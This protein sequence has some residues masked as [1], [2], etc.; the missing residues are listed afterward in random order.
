MADEQALSVDRDLHLD[1]VI[2]CTPCWV[3]HRARWGEAE[4]IAFELIPALLSV[5]RTPLEGPVTEAPRTPDPERQAAIDA[6][7]E[8]LLPV[9]DA[10][11]GADAEAPPLARL[12]HVE[13]SEA[14]GRHWAVMDGTDAALFQPMTGPWAM[15]E[16]RPVA[17]RLTEALAILHDAER[18]HL[19][20]SPNLLAWRDGKPVL[21]APAAEL[22]S[23]AEAPED[24]A[25]V[26]RTDLSPPELLDLSARSRVGPWTDI[27]LASATLFQLVTDKAPPALA[28][29][30]A[31][32]EAFH[33]LIVEE[34]APLGAQPGLLTAISR[35][36][37][38]RIA[39][40][41]QTIAQWAALIAEDATDP[42]P[43]PLL[44]E[45]EQ[46]EE[47]VLVN[48]AVPTA[49]PP[50][51]CG[52][53]IAWAV[54]FLIGLALPIGALAMTMPSWRLFLTATLAEAG[55]VALLIGFV[56][57][58]PA[59]TL[60]VGLATGYALVAAVMLVVGFGQYRAAPSDHW[61][62]VAFTLPML[63]IV[64]LALRRG[65]AGWLAPVAVGLAALLYAALPSGSLPNERAAP[66]PSPVVPVTPTPAPEPAPTPPPPAPEPAPV[67]P[68]VVNFANG[69]PISFA[70]LIDSFA[71][72]GDPDCDEPVRITARRN[73]DDRLVGL[74]I[75]RPNGD[76]WITSWEGTVL[77]TA[78]PASPPPPGMPTDTAIHLDS[79]ELAGGGEPAVNY[80]HDGYHLE[81]FGDRLVL[82]TPNSDGS[83]YEEYYKRCE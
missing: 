78:P 15:V 33:A 62:V 52:W 6:L 2:G 27:Y 81:L 35:G 3:V 74:T 29:R 21:Y 50:D 40:R 57:P 77:D 67:D 48:D 17:D 13:R 49:S 58:P 60:V 80:R 8:A 73:A 34:L 41:P 11:P 46:A 38:T 36:L 47:E 39:D 37:S 83:L 59:R 65:W 56:R 12:L 68:M 25:L 32:V 54:A 55:L 9:L 63:P 14:T 66:P 30:P 4:A 61:G 42:R 1:A 71:A 69:G 22:R 76:R 72:K 18:L 31:D 28:Q 10:W 23:V 53:A 26:A 7:A 75:R 45:R 19:G 79:I 16:A 51:G 24:L 5:E 70:R 44:P 43:L 20:I 64:L 82:Q